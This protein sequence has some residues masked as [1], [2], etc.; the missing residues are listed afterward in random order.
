MSQQSSIDFFH[1]AVNNMLA[2]RIPMTSNEVAKIW[3]EAKDIHKYEIITAYEDCS[4][5]DGEFV[6]GEQYH[7]LTYGN[8]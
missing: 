6:T 1:D 8:K 2:G 3:F 5:I 4:T 7:E